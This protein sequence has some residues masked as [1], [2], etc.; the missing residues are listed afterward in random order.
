MFNEI[1]GSIKS[2][3]SARLLASLTEESLKWQQIVLSSSSLELMSVLKEKCFKPGGYKYERRY[4][5]YPMES[6]K[7]FSV[8]VTVRDT[9]AALNTIIIKRLKESYQLSKLR[10]SNFRSKI[11][12]EN[13]G[14]VQ[15][16][17]CHRKIQLLFKNLF[18]KNP[19]KSLI[20]W[21]C[22]CEQ[23]LFR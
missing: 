19:E 17:D 15:W 11:G 8:V 9:F 12:I 5:F 14:H 3:A 16:T 13:K 21:L 22:Q 10:V 6:M 7:V 20:C 18:M 2:T 1:L 4:D 23:S